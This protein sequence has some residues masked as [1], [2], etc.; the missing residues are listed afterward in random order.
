MEFSEFIIIFA[1]LEKYYNKVDT[2][3]EKTYYNEFKNY[4]AQRF[5]KLCEMA[6]SRCEFFPKI[7]VLKNFETE[8]NNTYRQPEKKVKCDKCNGTGLLHY[9]KV[10]ED[11]KYSFVCKCTCENSKRLSKYIPTIEELRL[12]N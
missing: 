11:Y 7:S 2:E 3:L 5:S 1:K 10:V 8:I 4:S 12:N 6:I 9:I